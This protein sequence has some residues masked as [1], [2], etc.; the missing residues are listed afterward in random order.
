MNEEIKD[1]YRRFSAEDNIYTSDG[2]E[3][4]PIYPDSMLYGDDPS[5]F[6]YNAGGMVTLDSD[7]GHG[8]KHVYD[9]ILLRSGNAHRLDGFYTVCCGRDADIEKHKR[10]DYRTNPWNDLVTEIKSNGETIYKREIT[11]AHLIM[12]GLCRGGVCERSLDGI[13]FVASDDV[14]PAT[15]SIDDGS[16]FYNHENVKGFNSYAINKYMGFRF[17]HRRRD[18][19]ETAKVPVFFE[20]SHMMDDFLYKTSVSEV[21]KLSMISSRYT[22]FFRLS[23]TLPAGV[24]ADNFMRAMAKYMKNR[25]LRGN[26]IANLFG[27]PGLHLGGLSVSEFENVGNHMPPDVDEVKLTVDYDN[28]DGSIFSQVKAMHAFAFAKINPTIVFE[29]GAIT[30]C[31]GMFKGTRGTTQDPKRRQYETYFS[32]C[33]LKVDLKGR[34]PSAVSPYLGF[35]P[36]VIADCFKF[37]FLNQK[38]Y[39]AFFLNADMSACRDFA[40][41]FAEQVFNRVFNAEED[42]FSP[43]MVG[44]GSYGDYGKITIKCPRKASTPKEDWDDSKLTVWTPGQYEYNTTDRKW[45][46]SKYTGS[47]YQM[48]KYSHVAV[49]E[50]ILDLKYMTASG[51]SQAFHNPPGQIA[52]PGYRGLR[53]QIQEVRI[54]NLGNM[55]INFAGEVTDWATTNTPDWNVES[56][57]DASVVFMLNNMRDQSPYQPGKE[58][59]LF[60]LGAHYKL[61]IPKTWERLLTGP[62]INDLVRKGWILYIGDEEKS[63]NDCIVCAEEDV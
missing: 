46:E 53:S 45:T 2:K 1:S 22:G 29:N 4:S 54:R 39:D 33:K 56:M 61:R 26:D 38:S 37:S 55:D 10:F 52:W 49:I 21:F 51:I 11:F 5:V 48:C 24:E 50:P 30:N 35:A 47:M 40:G 44:H 17:D 3:L 15:A 9:P 25:P 27:S 60:L 20:L 58:D 28:S 23:T 34:K 57:S 41:A 43:E 12:M 19:A 6:R 14:I 16:L 7:G 31:K 59:E 18:E 8:W 13:A 36:T 42:G 63:I 32:P 62:M